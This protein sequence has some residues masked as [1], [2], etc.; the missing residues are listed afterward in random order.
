MS[1]EPFNA[2]RPRR[3][4]R[5]KDIVFTND[6]KKPELHCKRTSFCLFVHETLLLAETQI[7]WSLASFITLVLPNKNHVR[8]LSHRYN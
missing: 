1:I 7:F 3:M 2:L 6:I 5:M 8:L 4:R